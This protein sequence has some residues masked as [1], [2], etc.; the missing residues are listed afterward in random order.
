MEEKQI[1]TIIDHCAL[2]DSCNEA[3]LI[4]TH[5]SWLVL[6]DQY[7]F[8]VKKPH[9]LSFLDFSTLQKRKYYAYQELVLNRRLTE[10][11]YLQVLP[12]K[13]GNDHVAIGAE[14]GT[15]IDYAVQMRKLDVDHQMHLLLQKDQ[16]SD[17]DVQKIASIIGAFHQTTDVEWHA[18]DL[19]ALEQSFNDIA[20]V[21]EV[22]T[23]HLNDSKSD[24]IDQAIQWSNQF[25]EAHKEIFD[26][27][28]E[29]GMIR[30]CHG[31]LHSR[32]IFIYEKP[33]IFDCIEF[34]EAFRQIDVLNEIGFFTM[35]LE[36]HG[37]GELA[38]AFMDTYLNKFPCINTA[39][40][41]SLLTYYKAYRA[42]VRAKVTALK[43]DQLQE[44]AQRKEAV[45]NIKLYLD[46]MMQYLRSLTSH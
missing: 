33:V 43:V 22:V 7:V 25:L 8:K 5:I 44:E 14:E 17:E 35:D 3:Q 6:A 1:K 30:D 11:I 27:R 28:K 12:I 38:K 23:Q 26:Q 45:N 10:D 19:W 46:L 15:T 2:P 18:F 39:E 29:Q 16:V 37:Q 21:K 41:E 36:A 34:N 24:G 13:E 20:S 31:D 42:N 40:E 9:Q 4:E 32:N